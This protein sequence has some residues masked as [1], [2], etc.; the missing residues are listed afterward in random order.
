VRQLNN[1]ELNSAGDHIEENEMD[2]ASS[3][4]DGEERYIQSFGGEI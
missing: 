4:Y 1:E 3:T 2:E